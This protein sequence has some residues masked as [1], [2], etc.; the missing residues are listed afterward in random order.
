MKVQQ[1]NLLQPHLTPKQPP[2][3]TRHLGAVWGV[4]C[5]GLIL[6]TAWEE[7]DIADLT[8]EASS[9]QDQVLLLRQANEQSR[10]GSQDPEA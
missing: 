6:V 8:D 3:G 5:L 4:F 2:L 9:V 7:L 10:R 1:V